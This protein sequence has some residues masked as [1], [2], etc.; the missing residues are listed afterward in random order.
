L[1]AQTEV[2]QSLVRNVHRQ[3]QQPVIL[4][5]M[6]AALSG[7]DEITAFTARAVPRICAAFSAAGVTPTGALRVAYDQGHGGPPVEIRAGFPVAEGDEVPG[8]V[9]FVLP[10]AVALAGDFSG[11][12]TAVVD[13]WDEL[14]VEAESAGLTPGTQIEVYDRWVG[15]GSPDN[16]IELE[17]VLP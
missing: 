10:A 1:D 8:L 2:M 15:P 17:L 5:G 6:S 4:R 12:M 11:P 13:A 3:Q 7:V 14:A 16:R 9:R